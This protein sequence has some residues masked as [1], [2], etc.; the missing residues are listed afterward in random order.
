MPIMF[1]FVA[2]AHALGQID[3]LSVINPCWTCSTATNLTKPDLSLLATHNGI[4]ILLTPCVFDHMCQYWIAYRQRK[5]LV[6]HIRILLFTTIT[7][8]KESNMIESHMQLI[9]EFNSMKYLIFHAQIQ[10]FWYTI[11][12]FFL[13]FQHSQQATKSCIKL[14]IFWSIMKSH[15]NII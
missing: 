11:L 15:F 6:Y 7:P 12:A 10:W 1:M 4:M 3:G 2:P 8:Y 5:Y 14:I 13:C 9:D